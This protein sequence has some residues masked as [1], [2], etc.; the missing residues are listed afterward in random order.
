MNQQL[1]LHPQK[2]LMVPMNETV[3]KTVYLKRKPQREKERDKEHFN[4]KTTLI[5]SH[6][7]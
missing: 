2:T 1:S 3:T 5:L 7:K 6:D 4:N